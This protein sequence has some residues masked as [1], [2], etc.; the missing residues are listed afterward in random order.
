[1]DVVKRIKYNINIENIIA[2]RI[3]HF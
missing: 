1:M 3:I 2:T